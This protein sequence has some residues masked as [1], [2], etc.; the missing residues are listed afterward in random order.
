MKNYDPNNP[1][2]LANWFRKDDP[3]HLQAWRDLRQT[4]VWPEMFQAEMAQD[5]VV[6]HQDWEPMLDH[7]LRAELV[8][9]DLSELF[10]CGGPHLG[11]VRSWIQR[12]FRNGSRVTWGSNDE[13]ADTGLTVRQMEQLAEQI[14]DAVLDAVKAQIRS[15]N[16]KRV[17]AQIPD[18]LIDRG[19]HRIRS[20]SEVAE[21]AD[22]AQ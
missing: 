22:N 8:V 20:W 16:K 10:A 7:D 18:R 21:G 6:I 17:P 4:G 1:K 15:S 3:A 19:G 11:A 5:G 12:T 9:Q 13:L 2:M 14:K